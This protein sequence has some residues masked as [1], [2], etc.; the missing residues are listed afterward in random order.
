MQVL[1]AG[2]LAVSLEGLVD[3]EEETERLRTELEDLRKYQARVSKNLQN[4]NFVNRAP[5][6]VVER[7]RD[8]LSSTEARIERLVEILDR[9]SG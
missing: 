8:R 6:E 4:E 2:T 9:L 3:L 1:N 5:E 7:E